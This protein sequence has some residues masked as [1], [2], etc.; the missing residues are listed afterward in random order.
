[1]ADTLCPMSPYYF[2]LLLRKKVCY[3]P[4]CPTSLLFLKEYKFLFF[5]NFLNRDIRKEKWEEILIEDLDNVS[6]R[7]SI[8]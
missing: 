7:R 3:M 4:T 2:A 1:M 5:A 6:I 8:L